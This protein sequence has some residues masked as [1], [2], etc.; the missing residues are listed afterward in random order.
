MLE[1]ARL[2]QTHLNYLIRNASVQF[3]K[4]T[5]IYLL[6]TLT[7]FAAS[8]SC[9]GIYFLNTAPDFLNTKLKTKTKELCFAEFA[10]MHSGASKTPLWSAQHLTKDMLS[11]KGS[12]STNF[13][14]EERLH[15]DERA[16]II[17]YI[18]THFDRGQLSSGTNFSD[19]IAYKE[20]FSLANIVPQNHT[21]RVGVWA[22]IEENIKTL[23]KTHGEI[24][25]ISGPLFLSN[26]PQRIHNKV[27]VP[28]KLF[29]AI[30]IP[31]T[32]EGSAYL[33]K[34][35]MDKEYEVIGIAELEKISGISFF[36]RM[37]MSAKMSVMDLPTIKS[38]KDKNSQWKSMTKENISK[39]HL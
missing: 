34:N 30:Y 27:L 17:D 22:K 8:T 35:T 38:S 9:N 16:E 25:V 12:R 37:N 10:V 28:T 19:D 23:V 36:P 33:T 15:E 20:S 3:T 6:T 2:H 14:T 31:S 4:L 1:R 5:S 13:H 11:R 29:K 21:N 32:G 39:D 26:T 18:G 24:Y 7:L